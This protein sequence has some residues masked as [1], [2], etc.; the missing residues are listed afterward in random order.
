MNIIFDVVILIIYEFFVKR[1]ANF[2]NYWT[3]V[4]N[5][6]QYSKQYL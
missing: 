1:Y 6:K 3:L 5:I 4:Q 2:K